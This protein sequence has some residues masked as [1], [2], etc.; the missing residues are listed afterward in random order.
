VRETYDLPERPPFPIR[1]LALLA[2]FPLVA[3]VL[4]IVFP[5]SPIFVALLAISLLAFVFGS[6]GGVLRRRELREHPERR[7]TTPPSIER[8]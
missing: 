5:D 3:I 1:M 7:P 6:V 2:L 4:W 8:G